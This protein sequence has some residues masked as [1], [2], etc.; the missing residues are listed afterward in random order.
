MI[1]L[2]RDGKSRYSGFA[3]AKLHARLREVKLQTMPTVTPGLSLTKF[4]FP[5]WFQSLCE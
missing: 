3:Y 5:Q 1:P 4:V 2:A